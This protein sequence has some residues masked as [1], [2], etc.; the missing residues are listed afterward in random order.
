MFM[1]QV[2][3]FTTNFGRADGPPMD[4]DGAEK[5]AHER[6]VAGGA[7]ADLVAAQIEFAAR[8]ALFAPDRAAHAPVIESRIQRT[9]DVGGRLAEPVDQVPDEGPDLEVDRQP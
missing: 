4:R 1:S 3:V 8:V 7:Y 9:V 5:G 6:R 2:P